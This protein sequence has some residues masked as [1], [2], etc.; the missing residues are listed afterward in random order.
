[1][2]KVPISLVQP[3]M[4]LAKPV[5]NE[6]GMP[7]CA[8]GTELT[9]SIIDRLRRLNVPF[10]TLKGRP[11]DMGETEPSLQERISKLRERFAPVQGDPTMERVRVAIEQAV[12]SESM[13]GGEDQNGNEGE[14]GE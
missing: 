6:A 8:E 14:P 11:V 4:V 10:L 7:L 13:E 5:L 2:Q 3:G 9:E 1:M 12:I